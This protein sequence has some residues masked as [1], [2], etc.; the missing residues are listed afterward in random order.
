MICPICKK[1]PGEE[2][3]EKFKVVIVCKECWKLPTPRV[4]K[5]PNNEIQ[6]DIVVI[7][8][9]KKFLELDVDHIDR[10]CVFLVKKSINSE[11]RVRCG[12]TP[13]FHWIICQCSCD[14]TERV[15]EKHRDKKCQCCCRRPIGENS[16]PTPEDIN[17][18]QENAIR[19]MEDGPLRID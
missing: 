3:I 11:D 17:P 6:Y 12:A 7:D 14:C 18:S 9:R 13:A 15:C 19:I 1:N 2:R 4:Y 8:D 10:G 5:E 16:N